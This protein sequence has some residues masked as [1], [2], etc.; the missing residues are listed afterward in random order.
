MN[1]TVYSKPNCPQCELAKAQIS[2]R[3]LKYKEVILD[4]GQHKFEHLEYITRDELLAL[5][6]DAKT[7][8]QIFLDEK[9]IGGYKELI[10]LL[11]SQ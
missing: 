2:N 3:Q 4:V 5:I 11:K 1:F 9:Y 6:P 8:P 7:M 10:P